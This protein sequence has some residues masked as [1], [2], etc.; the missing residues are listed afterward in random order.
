MILEH[1]KRK[2]KIVEQ[3]QDQKKPNEFLRTDKKVLRISVTKT[4]IN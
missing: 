3:E 1:T 2:D 4:K